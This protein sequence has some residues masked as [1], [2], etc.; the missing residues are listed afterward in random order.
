MI[1]EK[2]FREW[3]SNLELKTP[4]SGEE[5][6]KKIIDKFHSIFDEV[7]SFDLLFSGGLDSTTIAFLAKRFGK[8]FT[9]IT[10]GAKGSPDIMWAEGAAEELDFPI[11]I[12]EFTKDDV[13]K[14]LKKIIKI[15]NSDEPEKVSIAIPIYYA[16]KASKSDVVMTGLGSE[17][18]FAGYKRHEEAENINMEC[19]KGL[20]RMW[21]AD[22]LRDHTL[23]RHYG[24][25]HVLPYL[26]EELAEYALN[27]HGELKIKDS[28]TKWVLRDAASKMG[29]PDKFAWRGRKSAE[30]G[31]GTMALLEGIAKEKNIQLK[32]LISKS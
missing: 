19:L 2:R 16:L 18:I 14:D 13:K 23:M 9:A 21:D 27:I 28:F 15:I 31:S 12:V 29:V 10:A 25:K 1:D 3:S 5:L 11:R 20:K 26:N 7:E 30:E 6:K 4:I 24:K 32:E 22:L 8:K 17:E